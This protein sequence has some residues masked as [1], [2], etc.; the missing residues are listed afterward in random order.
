[1]IHTAHEVNE[2][3]PGLFLLLVVLYLSILYVRTEDRQYFLLGCALGGLAIAFKLTAGIAVIFLG[4]AFVLV[5][6][7][8]PDPI[9]ALWQPRL[10]IYGLILGSILI[11]VG[12]PN[13]LLRGPEWL[14]EERLIGSLDNKTAAS[15]TP[16]GYNALLTY[17]NGLGLPLAIASISGVPLTVHRLVTKDNQPKGEIV[18]LTGIISYLV[19]F[20]VLWQDFNTHHVLLSIPLLLLSLGITISRYF[21]TQQDVTR[22][23]FIV[24]LLTTSLYAGAGLYQF[25]NDPRDETADWLAK[26]A[27]PDITVTTFSDSPAGDGLVHGFSIDHYKFG[28]EPGDPGEP[29]TEWLVSTPDRNPEYILLTGNRDANPEQHPRRA[30]FYDRLINGDHYGYVVAAEF[31]E[32]PEKQ[33]RITKILTAGVIPHLE[34]RKDYKIILSKNESLT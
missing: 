22:V 7:N 21:E 11:Y 34:K 13:L 14:I 31:G 9:G 1:V 5:A 20:F 18:L 32:S 16:Q 24:L 19:V 27:N 12:I 6:L 10:L 4:T 3:T 15:V 25:T 23:I 8:K 30:E 17:L 2:D 28:R 29:Y 33:S 26:N